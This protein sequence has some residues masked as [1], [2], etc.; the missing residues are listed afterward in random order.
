MWFLVVGIFACSASLNDAQYL[1]GL[2][3]GEVCSDRSE[4]QWICTAHKQCTHVDLKVMR[5]T[6]CSFKGKLPIICCPPKKKMSKAEMNCQRSTKKICLRDEDKFVWET[7]PPL[8][9]HVIGGK[10]SKGRSRQFA[11]LIGYGPK[12]NIDWR[13][14]GSLVSE[15]WVLS[16]AHC[17]NT[18]DSGPA[19]WARLGELDHSTN[20]DDARP[21]DQRIVQRINHP[22]YKEPL[23]YHDIALYKLESRVL[24]DQYVA[25]ICLHTAF[26]IDEPKGTVVGWGRTDFA[27]DVSSRLMEVDITLIDNPECRRLYGSND[28]TAPRGIERLTMLCA[29][30]KEGGKDA[31]IGD[32]GGPMVINQPGSCLKKQVGITSFGRDCGLPN[33]PGIYTRVSSYVGWIESIVWP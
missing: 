18:A 22:Q 15:L 1:L 21:Q 10:P 5:P 27:D 20:N 4:G 26:D 23:K 13:C 29:G 33:S 32:S 9:N 19:A 28:P 25:P 12:N 31:C 11:A 17:T 6:I 2:A 7:R 14:G 24:F 30:E 16:A 8:V 3:E